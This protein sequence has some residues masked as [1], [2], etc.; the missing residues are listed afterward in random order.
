MV[1]TILLINSYL[2]IWFDVYLNA[3]LK[4]S[5]KS[6]SPNLECRLL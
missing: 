4:K 5:R 1:P 6:N 3:I 2:L